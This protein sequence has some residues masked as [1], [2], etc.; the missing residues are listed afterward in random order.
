MIAK[1]LAYKISTVF[2]EATFAISLEGKAK[3]REGHVKLKGGKGDA[4]LL[5]RVKVGCRD[6][7]Q[8]ADQISRVKEFLPPMKS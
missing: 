6:F 4:S 2:S 8:R 3:T 5:R 7:C 1:K